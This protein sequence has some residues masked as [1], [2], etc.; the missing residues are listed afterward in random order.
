MV[1][2]KLNIFSILSYEFLKLF[3]EIRIESWKKQKENHKYKIFE[4][5][6]YINPSFH[7]G[8]FTLRICWSLYESNS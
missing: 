4:M 6:R 8:I 2:K 7:E 5:S 1:S 3:A